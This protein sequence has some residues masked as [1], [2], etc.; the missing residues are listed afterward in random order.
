MIVNEH[1]EEA[2]EAP[3]AAMV[4]SQ[5][6]PILLRAI[7][8]VQ[9]LLEAQQEITSI[10]A[11]VLTEDTD[12]GIIKGTKRPTLFKAG[13]ERVLRSFGCIAEYRVL[14]ET[15]D[16][17]RSV[18]I[19]R[20]QWN[21]A[22]RDDKSFTMVEDTTLGF[23]RYVIRCDVLHQA[24]GVVIA[25]G[26]GACSTVEQKYADRPNELE[27]TILK[28]AC[29]RALV[30]GALNAF[31]LSDRFTQDVEDADP[32]PQAERAPA[33]AAAV[34]TAPPQDSTPNADSKLVV[35]PDG[36]PIQKPLGEWT[37]KQLHKHYTYFL[38]HPIVKSQYPVFV[39]ALTE[40]ALDADA[41]T[42]PAE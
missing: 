15:I 8:P 34:S 29:K 24:S 22:H 30:A 5:Q 3:K 32:P 14:S 19:K 1:G 38:E 20:K 9:E 7:A 26:L 18:A 2:E 4:R 31:A 25:Y 27:N 35:P 12:Y 10:I 11:K 13:A 39:E 40:V 23:Y 41:I 36:Y 17:A 16:P 42:A 33:P 21:N 37:V 28:M 6:K